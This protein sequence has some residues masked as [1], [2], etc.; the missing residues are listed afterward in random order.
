MASTTTSL[1]NYNFGGIRR[2]DAVFMA[3]KI[4]CSNCQ[5]VE[6]FFTKLNSGVGIR[7]V[8][9]NKAITDDIPNDENVIGIFESIQNKESIFFVY[10]ESETK[11]RIYTLDRTYESTTLV[12]DNLSTTGNACGCDFKQ[13][14]LDT[15]IFS[16]GEDVI[17][18]YTDTS[19][20]GSTL[21]VA[22]Y[23]ITN[24]TLYTISGSTVTSAY[25]G[26]SGS[27]GRLTIPIPNTEDVFYVYRDKSLDKEIN[28]TKYYGWSDGTNNYYTTENVDVLLYDTEGNRVYG[29]GLCVFDSRLW[30]FNDVTVWYSQQG[31]CRNFRYQDPSTITSAG[32]IIFV[33]PVTAIYPYLGTLAVFH[34]DSSALVQLDATTVFKTTDE[35]PGGCAG[36]DSLVFHGTD[37]YF[38]DDTKKGVFSFQQVVNGDKTL[39][40]NIA[41]DIQDELLE[42]K[43]NDL[44]KIRTL[45]VV[46]SDRNEVW[47]LVPIEDTYTV[48]IDGNDVEKQASIVLIFDYIRGEWIKRKCQH[49]NAIQMIDNS[50]FSGGKQVYA[51]YVGNDFDGDFIKSEYVCTIFNLGEDNT[52]KITKFPPRLAV[53]SSYSN[54]F[55]VKYVKNYDVLKTPKTKEIKGKSTKNTLVFNSG[56]KWNDGS[57]YK[58]KG[59]SIIVKIPS[60]TFKALEITFYTENSSQDFCIKNIEFSKI[61]IKQV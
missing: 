17:Y 7:T 47:F 58:V 54:H 30:M 43:Q 24:A 37:L 35:S 19:Q 25:T 59:V 15:F 48:K 46:T 23:S 28:N 10:T 4:T 36:Y 34:K 5:N 38:Y 56:A 26:I 51:E 9:G 41:Y 2:K 16:N 61:K 3:D 32:H 21:T 33:K 50:L 6:L 8:N 45:S 57:K 20:T 60:A 14:W 52:L 12:V 27:Y 42:I 11:G 39:G 55:W 31:E 1:I 22:P 44:N 13:G 29:L 49:I 40:N 18:L 53:D